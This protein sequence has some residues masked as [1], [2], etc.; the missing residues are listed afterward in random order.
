MGGPGGPGAS[1]AVGSAGQAALDVG[2]VIVFVTQAG[3]RVTDAVGEFV[4]AITS[5]AGAAAPEGSVGG[6][7]EL[8]GAAGAD[9]DPAADTEK[10]ST[11]LHGQADAARDAAGRQLRRKHATYVA[12]H[13]DGK[14]VV[15]CS[16]NPDGCAEDD[17]AR[18]LGPD[19]QITKAYGWRRN[20]DT[21]NLEWTERPV[22]VKCQAKYRPDQFPEDVKADPEGK[23]Q[24]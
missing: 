24:R 6:A 18:Q 14:V 10:T 17:V 23:W 1:G 20:K 9:R 21:E 2:A 15:G 11:D 5:G 19:A 16:S 3:A 22:C 13:K 12:G 4:T 7:G 8:A